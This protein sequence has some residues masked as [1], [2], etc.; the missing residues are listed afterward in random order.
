ML[1]KL[2]II[3][4]ALA[5]VFGV[6][7]I[8]T[9]EDPV[10]GS[11]CEMLVAEHSLSR[12][13]LEGNRF[14]L[15][16]DNS[17]SMKGYMDFAS[18]ANSAEF[19]DAKRT[20]IS[21]LSAILDNVASATGIEPVTICGGKER[22]HKAFITAFQNSTLFGG[23]T[24]QLSDMMGKAAE[25]AGDSTIV[26]IFTDMVLSAGKKATLQSIDYNKHHLEDLKGEIYSVATQLRDKGLEVSIVRYL[27]D[28]NGSYYYNYQENRSDSLIDRR[29]KDRPYYLML[30]GK[31][32]RL[33]AM[34][35]QCLR[36]D[37]A[38][39]FSTMCDDAPRYAA[40]PFTIQE[41]PEFWIIDTDASDTT[42]AKHPVTLWT[43]ADLGGEQSKCTI[44][45]AKIDIPCY[46]SPDLRAE[47]ITGNTLSDV[48][49]VSNTEWQLTLQPF[50]KLPKRGEICFNLVSDKILWADD[51]RSM[52]D[53]CDIKMQ[54]MEGKTWGLSSFIAG[55]SEAY[56]IDTTPYV[57]AKFEL[58][59]SKE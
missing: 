33:N 57:S 52:E 14:T 3:F 54:D 29:M 15:I 45:F 34:I 59:L 58:N 4:I 24:T 21:T 22:G 38:E 25:M 20:A 13:S 12:A 44:T 40:Q 16:M 39:V 55:L 1:K 36:L 23:Q 56:K 47:V 53:D 30:I 19:R 18:K 11:R 17:G 28:F 41:P 6:I 31:A 49:K 26:G 7:G 9:A 2:I 42:A 8:I 51:T 27:S 10:H 5:V 32:D 37:V 46:A 43:T 50:D 35:T 48:R